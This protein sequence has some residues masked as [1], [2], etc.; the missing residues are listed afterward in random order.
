MPD[1]ADIGSN[2]G[3][4]SEALLPAGNYFVARSS[5]AGLR[6]R[7]GAGPWAT[8]RAHCRQYTPAQSAYKVTTDRLYRRGHIR[9]AVRER[10]TYRA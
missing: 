10:G 2:A 4:A 6:T 1:A 3:P 7:T 5:P 9:R 8:I